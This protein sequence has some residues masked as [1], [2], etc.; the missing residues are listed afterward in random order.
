MSYINR[1]VSG[2]QVDHLSLKHTLTTTQTYTHNQR[3]SIQL[4]KEY[5][6]QL[7]GLQKV[8]LFMMEEWKRG[9]QQYQENKVFL[10]A[11]YRSI[12]KVMPVLITQS[13]VVH[14]N[15]STVW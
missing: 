15:A 8:D 14:Q 5:L 2:H 11:C 7:L 9:I 3:I 1:S 13:F 10:K 4:S 6:F 12:V